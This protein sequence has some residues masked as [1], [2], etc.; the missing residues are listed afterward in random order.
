MRTSSQ[1]IALPFSLAILLAACGGSANPPAPASSP[2]AASPSTVPS[3]VAKAASAPASAAASAKP[4]ASAAASAKPVTSSAPTPGK[5]SSFYS[6]V[7]PTFAPLWI[8]KEAG[9][10]QKN[11]LNVDVQLIQN[12]GGTAA[13]I[14]NQVQI[15]IGGAADLLGPVTN[16]ADLQALATF[17][18]TYPYVF[19]VADNIKTPADLKGKK[20]GASQAGGSDYVALLSVLSKL[21]LDFQKDVSILFVGGIPA[22][23]AALL[24]GNIVGTLTAPPETL[25]IEGKGYHSLI[26]VTSLNLPSATSTLTAH[27]AWIQANHASVQKF[28][29]SLIEAIAREKADKPYAEQV[30]SKYLKLTDKTALDA[31]YNFF[32]GKI[33]PSQPDAKVEQ[34]NDTVVSLGKTNPAIKSINLSTVVDDSFVQDA[35]KRGVGK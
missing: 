1:K 29:D 21:N 17:T 19:E 13:L 33:L 34:F 3:A 8:A 11:G 25:K 12:P 5:I 32:S 14:A 16:G 10:F 27:K 15:G 7:S 2:A 30:M 6:T 35:V 22:R 31:A 24:G 20:I 26:D 23:T 28:V 4:P 9:I 18:T